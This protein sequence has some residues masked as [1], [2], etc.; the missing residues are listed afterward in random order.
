MA[1]HQIIDQCFSRAESDGLPDRAGHEDLLET[2]APELERLRAA[3]ETGGDPVLAAPAAGD[4][5]ALR[6]VAGGFAKSFEDVVVL[7]VGGSSLGGQAVLGLRDLPGVPVAARP[8]LHFPDNADPATFAATFAGLDLGRTGV[9]AISRSGD[10]DE[11]VAQMLLYLAALGETAPAAGHALVITGPAASPLRRIAEARKIPILNHDPDLAGRYSV[12]S[13][14]G[15]VPALIAG[16]DGEA[17]RAGALAALDSALNVDAPGDSPAAT[18]AALQFALN[19]A[20]FGTAI[21]FHYSDR[22]ASFAQWH[23][24][25]WAESLGKDGAG[26]L[27]VPARGASDQHSQLQLYLEGPNDKA[28]TVISVEAEEAGPAIDLVQAEEAGAGHL[29]GH[30]LGDLFA[31]ERRATVQSLAGK[32]RPLREIRLERLDEAA[33][34]GLMMHFMLETMLTASLMGVDPFGQPAVEAG[35]LLTRNFLAGDSS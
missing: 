12:F 7:G 25:L 17:L 32:G 33:L 1:F 29:A 28:F 35:K 30:G 31:A 9:V 21:M 2:L 20:G 6:A 3:L 8:R 34:G 5:E 13:A 27:P 16:L 23:R 15:M 4:M 14:V 10:T 19:E 11:T 22:L 24:Q 18:G 26:S